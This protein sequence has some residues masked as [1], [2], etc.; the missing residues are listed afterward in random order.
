MGKDD[1]T[2]DELV[3]AFHHFIMLYADKNRSLPNSRSEDV[4]ALSELLPRRNNNAVK[5]K[6]SNFMAAYKKWSESRGKPGGPREGL[7]HGSVGDMRT[8]EKYIGREDELYL[9]FL[10]ALR[11]LAAGRAEE[12]PEYGPEGRTD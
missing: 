6:I 10:A 2:D 3:V 7:S 1:W 5:M 12:A 8:L 11:R 4:S 9:E